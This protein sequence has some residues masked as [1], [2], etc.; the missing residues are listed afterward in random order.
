MKILVTAA[1]LALVYFLI[2]RPILHT[3]ENITNSTNETIQRSMNSVNKAFDS[4]NQANPMTQR[5]IT[6]KLK[7]K[8]F[9]PNAPVVKCINRANQNVDRIERCAKRYGLIP[10]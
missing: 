9:G 5:Q 4:S 6:T 7:T 8:Q 1:T 2:L 10:Q 3:T